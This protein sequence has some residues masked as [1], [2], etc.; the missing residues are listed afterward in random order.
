MVVAIKDWKEIFR[1]RLPK[2]KLVSNNVY[3]TVCVYLMYWN[4]WRKISLMQEKTHFMKLTF[5]LSRDLRDN[6]HKMVISICRLLGKAICKK[7]IALHL[8]GKWLQFY[9]ADSVSVTI[10]IQS[11]LKDSTRKKNLRVNIKLYSLVSGEEET[12]KILF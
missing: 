8:I 4:V 6:K 2:K 10:F 12:R 9:F 3:K 1:C 11:F 7:Q 5:C